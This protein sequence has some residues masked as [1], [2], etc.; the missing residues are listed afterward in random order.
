MPPAL[1]T[2]PTRRPA[3]QGL[4]RQHRR[5]LGDAR[6]RRGSGSRPPGRTA[7]RRRP[8]LRASRSPP[9]TA[10]SGLRSPK[11]RAVRANFKR[12]AERLEVQ[13]RRPRR[14]RRR[15]RRRA[16]RCW[17]RRA[18]RRARRTSGRRRPGR[19]ARSSTVKP[20]PPDCEATASPPRSGS[21][22][23]ND[24]LSGPAP[25][26]LSTPC[27]FGPDQPDAVGPGELDE[28]PVV[29][30]AT[31]RRSPTTRRPP[32]PHR[33][34]RR[35]RSPRPPRPAAPRPSTRS[36]GPGTAPNV[37]VRRH[38]GD[39]AAL[40]VGRRVHDATAARR[41]RP[42]RWSRARPG[43]RPSAER[44]TP[45]TATLSGAS[46][47]RS[48]RASERHSR[49]SDASRAAAE[50]SVRSSTDTSPCSVRRE[51]AKPA[52]AEDPQ[53]PVVVGQHVGVEAVEPVRA[54]QCGQV[55]QQQAAETA[56]RGPGRR[57]GRRPRP[58]PR[59]APRPW[60]AR[61]AGHGPA[62]R[63]RTARCAPGRTAARRTGGR[64]RGWR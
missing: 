8:R 29:G 18:W 21:T 25:A 53:H 17:T 15:P 62:R 6:R 35:R 39:R 63:A 3:G 55:L 19:C 60:P 37:R 40:A 16:G 44:R 30:V 22:R 33:P 56:A 11:R 1:L 24:A 12:V 31:L 26:W 57:R 50:T 61:R 32:R 41:T 45:T 47:G 58:A 27:E 5:S 7:Q 46:S 4:L 9:T 28:L 48:E 42:R 43:R 2:M 49:R 51:M 52:P 23:A 14:G 64:R 34:R 54:A 38:P 36:S 20:T 13:R 10:S 59:T